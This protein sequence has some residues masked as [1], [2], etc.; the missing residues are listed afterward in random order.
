[1]PKYIHWTDTVDE[2]KLDRTDRLALAAS[3]LDGYLWDPILGPKPEGFDDLPDYAE[4]NRFTR[5]RKPCKRDFT[6]PA[7]RGIEDIIGEAAIS[8]FWWIHGLGETEEAWFQWYTSPE[9]PF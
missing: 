3:R 5:K 4:P 9:G 6:R 1:M 8:R 2:S 7:R